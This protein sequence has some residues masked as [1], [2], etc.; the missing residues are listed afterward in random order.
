VE[1]PAAVL[2]AAARDRRLVRSDPSRR[3]LPPP[4]SARDLAAVGNTGRDG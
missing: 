2:R 1:L 3:P 4:R